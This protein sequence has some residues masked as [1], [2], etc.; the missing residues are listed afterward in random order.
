M[1]EVLN[2]FISIIITGMLGTTCLFL[3]LLIDHKEELWDTIRFN[4]KEVK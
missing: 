4:D 2:T 1:N 3:L